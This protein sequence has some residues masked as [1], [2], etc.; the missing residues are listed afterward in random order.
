MKF[1]KAHPAWSI[2]VLTVCLL[3]G[4][5]A[6]FAGAKRISPVSWGWYGQVNAPD[7]VAIGGYDPVAYRSGSAAKGDPR[8]AV[9][10]RGGRWLFASAESKALFDA[11]R[12]KYA[13]EFGGFCAYAASKGF[14]AKT[15]PTAWRIEQGKLYLFNDASVRDEWVSEL[16]Q[17]VIGRGEKAWATRRP[18]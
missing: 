14:T 13:P 3:A 17:G 9:D 1:I 7:G 6:A 16:G 11:N 12:E 5:I 4:A 18:Q 8:Y 15:E 10:W 2:A